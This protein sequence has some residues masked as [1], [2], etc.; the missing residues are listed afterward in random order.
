MLISTA[1]SLVAILLGMIAVSLVLAAGRWVARRQYWVGGRRG[2]AAAV[3]LIVAGILGLLSIDL[4]IY[5][6]LSFERAVAEVRVREANAR[7]KRYAVSVIPLDGREHITT[8]VL[9]G[10][11]WLLSARVQKWKPWANVVG[12]DATYVLEQV[13]NKYISATEANGKPITACAINIPSDGLYRYV[14]E[15]WFRWLA[16]QFQA[17]ERQFGSANYMPLADGAIYI[18]L[19]TQAGLNTEPLNDIARLADAKRR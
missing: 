13:S 19:M 4:Q 6:R 3:L 8:C 18:V 14:T 15:T 17:E 1:F 7:E 9:Q 16:L 5:S 12:L 2:L 10:D 11:E